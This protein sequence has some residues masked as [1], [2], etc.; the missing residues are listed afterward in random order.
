[1]TN[2]KEE[3]NKD[4]EELI[5]FGDKEGLFGNYYTEWL[6]PNE[7]K[8]IDEYSD[9]NSGIWKVGNNRK[10]YCY[11]LNNELV[12]QWN[13]V[14]DYKQEIFDIYTIVILCNICF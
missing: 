10:L 7:V 11:N 13:S 3:K 5:K 4:L 14:D 9:A 12:N 6:N 2:I 8:I 1:M